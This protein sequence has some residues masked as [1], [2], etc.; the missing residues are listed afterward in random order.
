M[1]CH[2]LCNIHKMHSI[3]LDL[4]P[5]S[6][7]ISVVSQLFSNIMMRMNRLWFSCL[8]I[9]NKKRADLKSALHRYLLNGLLWPHQPQPKSLCKYKMIPCNHGHCEKYTTSRS[10]HD[11]LLAIAICGSMTS[12]SILIAVIRFLIRFLISTSP[13]NK[14]KRPYTEYDNTQNYTNR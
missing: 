3:S 2:F 4:I 1:R 13:M 12:K 8:H 9:M 7:Y 14:V 10:C 6:G 11:R 5:R